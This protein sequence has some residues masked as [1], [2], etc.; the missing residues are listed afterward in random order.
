MLL[1]LLSFAGYTTMEEA[2]VRWALGLLLACLLGV[3]IGIGITMALGIHGTTQ[4][5]PAT[6]TD[7][8]S[9][10]SQIQQSF[11]GYLAMTAATSRMEKFHGYLAIRHER[12]GYVLWEI[13]D[14]FTTEECARIRKLAEAAGMEDSTVLN[15]EGEPT[16]DDSRTKLQEKT[17]KSR[18]AWLKD[19]DDPVIERFAALAEQFTGQPRGAQEETQVV[20]YETG[21]QFREHYDA[22]ETQKHPEYCERLNEGKG[23][24]THTLLLYLND[25]FEG[26]ETTFSKLGV[27]IVPKAGK[28]VLFENVGPDGEPLAASLHG[29][30]EVLRGNKWIATKWSHARAPAAAP[31]APQE[32]KVAP[33]S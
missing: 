28:A 2:T 9:L 13:L 33:T 25:D 26:G 16:R 18:Q 6:V 4:P 21:G 19:G 12:Q 32:E 24:R 5:S 14:L 17:R 22:C 10:V 23:Q 27:S 3:A 31:S 8:A 29:G 1:P 15:Y 30:A 11:M 7:E 20:A